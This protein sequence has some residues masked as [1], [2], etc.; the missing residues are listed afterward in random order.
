[1]GVFVLCDPGNGQ[2]GRL[3]GAVSGVFH[4]PVDIDGDVG[5]LEVNALGRCQLGRGRWCL[6]DD[7]GKCRQA[8][9]LTLGVGV[10]HGYQYR[11]GRGIAGGELGEHILL[12]PHAVFILAGCIISRN[13]I[14]AAQRRLILIITLIQVNPVLKLFIRCH[15]RGVGAPQYGGGLIYPRHDGRAAGNHQC[16]GIACRHGIGL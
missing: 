4:R 6:H 5:I 13:G 1:M 2:C 15:Q 12:D 10:R 14:E 9:V 16:Q 11:V 8:D 3:R 7:P